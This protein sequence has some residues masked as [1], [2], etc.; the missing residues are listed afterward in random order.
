[1]ALFTPLNLTLAGAG[2]LA[3]GVIAYRKAPRDEAGRPN[4]ARVSLGAAGG[5]VAGFAVG[6][7]TEMGAEAVLARRDKPRIGMLV[8]SA[9]YR[10]I[11]HDHPAVGVNTTA[12]QISDRLRSEF[13][14][15]GCTRQRGRVERWLAKIARDYVPGQF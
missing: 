10:T 2:A 6:N 8:D 13:L 14:T 12:Q 11:I 1:M 3:G 4:L 7:L 5:A 15:E 9:G